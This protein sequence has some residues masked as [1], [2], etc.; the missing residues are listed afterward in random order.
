MRKRRNASAPDPA[1]SAVPIFRIL[2]GRLIAV[3]LLD[4]GLAQ[5]VDAGVAE[6]K[7]HP[8]LMES[9][10]SGISLDVG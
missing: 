4:A 3:G 1:S 9:Q 5:S 10:M 7:N 8:M 6:M 2:L